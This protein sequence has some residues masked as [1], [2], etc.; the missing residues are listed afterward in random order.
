MNLSAQFFISI[1]Q[2]KQ[3]EL[4]NFINWIRLQQNHYEQHFFQM[5][6]FIDW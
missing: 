3:M 5:L 6:P 2:S 4:E 1:F